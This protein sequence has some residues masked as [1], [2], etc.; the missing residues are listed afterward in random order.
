LTVNVATP[1][2][3]VATIN[4]NMLYGSMS[5]TMQTTLTNARKSSSEL[6]GATSSEKAWSGDLRHRTYRPNTPRI[7]GIDHEPYPEIPVAIFS[8]S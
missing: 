2:L 1:S 7:R 3:L 8:T 6:D 4:A 5:S